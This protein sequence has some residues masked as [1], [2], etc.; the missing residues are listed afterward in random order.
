MQPKGLCERVEERVHEALVDDRLLIYHAV[1]IWSIFL[2][3]V[4]LKMTYDVPKL[5]IIRISFDS[6]I[7]L[8]GANKTVAGVSD[9][10]ILYSQLFYS[11]L[12]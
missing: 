1:F 10:Y 3:S 4:S 6:L 8:Y 12:K 2:P 9:S 11:I 7:A 5:P